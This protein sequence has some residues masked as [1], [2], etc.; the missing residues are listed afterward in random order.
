MKDVANQVNGRA[1]MQLVRG[2]TLALLV[3]QARSGK[4]DAVPP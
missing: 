2:G 1:L 4:A 3:V